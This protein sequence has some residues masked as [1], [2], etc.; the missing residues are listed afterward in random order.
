VGPLGFTGLDPEGMLVD[1]FDESG[2]MMD[3]YNYPYY[4]EH[5]QSLGYEKDCDWVEYEVMTPEFVPEKA[6]RV[7]ELVLKRKGLTLVQAKKAADLI[8][9][10]KNVFELLNTAYANLYGY[11]EL[12]PAQVDYYVNEYFSFINPLFNKVIV[13]ADGKLAAFGLVF[14]SLAAALRR[15]RG[16]LFPFGFIRLLRAS[17]NPHRLN[18]G[19]IAVRP[20]IQGSGI[21]AV[22]M[23]E[24]TRAAIEHGVDRAET[25]RELEENVKVRSLWKSYNAR[26]HRRR[27]AFFKNLVNDG[28]GSSG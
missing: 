5:L 14:P 19:L 18:L 6:V 15:S 10:A 2:T 1:G 25:G 24:I 8:P 7:G 26:Q 11:V 21:P 4:P 12:T 27:R 20:E 17:R 9:Y 16:R 13:D 28:P 23:T 3:I 22:L